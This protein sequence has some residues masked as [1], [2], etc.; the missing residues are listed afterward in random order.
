[1]QPRHGHWRGMTCTLFVVC[2][3]QDTLNTL[4]C[5]YLPQIQCGITVCSSRY[6]LMKP[7]YL[8]LTF[9]SQYV[10]F[11]TK[12]RYSDV[13]YK[14]KTKYG[15]CCS[16]ATGDSGQKSYNYLIIHCILELGC[17]MAVFIC[18][19]LAK[20]EDALASKMN[21]VRQHSCDNCLNVR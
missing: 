9:S 15:Q 11:Q 8:H 20:R 16:Q 3:Y 4:V 5:V 12:T 21:R 17:V 14:L 10:C 6:L 18:L 19:N 13:F 7:K 2:H 1:M